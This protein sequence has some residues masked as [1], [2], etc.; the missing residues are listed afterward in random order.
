MFDRLLAS[1]RI[2][3]H[4]LKGKTD[5]TAKVFDEMMIY[6]NSAYF[7]EHW[8]QQ[9]KDYENLE[10]DTA[11]YSQAY[12]MN[13]QASRDALDKIIRDCRND[14]RWKGAAGPPKSSLKSTLVSQSK[15]APVPTIVA[16]VP[17]KKRKVGHSM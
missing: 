3:D 7:E 16:P 11:L 6:V 13:P 5:G 2:S 15:N 1:G 12:N 10:R 17:A 14:N 8:Q 9:G 4:Q